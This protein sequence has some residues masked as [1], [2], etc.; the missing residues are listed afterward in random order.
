MQRLRKCGEV[1]R[2][3]I[4][5]GHTPLYVF[6]ANLTPPTAF[7]GHLRNQGPTHI[8]RERKKRSLV[9]VNRLFKRNIMPPTP[10]HN[11]Q[12]PAVLRRYRARAAEP[13]WRC[14]PPPAPAPMPGSALL[15]PRPAQP[16]GNEE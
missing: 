10:T 6:R 12:R 9:L 14:A 3:L 2:P 11:T 16:R 4:M 8:R 7:N 5:A 1:C 13:V 15:R